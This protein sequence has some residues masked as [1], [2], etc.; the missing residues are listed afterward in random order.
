MAGINAGNRRSWNELA[1]DSA[2]RLFL[3]L[4]FLPA[5]KSPPVCTMGTQHQPA[6]SM[7]LSEQTSSSDWCEHKA[8][9]W[10]TIKA[11]MGDTGVKGHSNRQL[12]TLVEEVFIIISYKQGTFHCC[13][14]SFRLD[15]L[16]GWFT[17]QCWI[18]RQSW[19]IE[20]V[21]VTESP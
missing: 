1:P 12:I 13:G 4:G 8:A 10:H 21:G 5:G 18:V 11:W 19:Y 14:Q 20:V 7:D 6:L 9:L 17:K 15:L 3:S 2:C 16:R